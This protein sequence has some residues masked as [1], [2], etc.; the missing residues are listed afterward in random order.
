MKNKYKICIVIPY[1]G[2]WPEW[3]NYFLL[4][5]KYNSSIDWQFFTDC[6]TPEIHAENLTFHPMTLTEF[7]ELAN[8]QLEIQLSVRH[9]YK[10]CDLKPAY[11][12]IFQKY[13]ENY[14]FWGYGDLDLVYGKINDFISD[15]ILDDYDI[16]SNHTDFIAGHFCILRNT[17]QIIHL[18]RKGAYYKKAFLQSKYTGFDEQI[19]N[20]KIST[21]P[22]NLN[23]S[24]KI[25]TIYHLSLNS[26]VNSPVKDVLRPFWKIVRKKGKAELKDF[27]TIVSESQQNEE[28]KVIY[29]TTFQS[30]LMFL[31]RKN[32]NWSLKWDHGKLINEKTGKEILYFHFILSKNS[33]KFR[34]DP[35]PEN[36]QSF[37]IQ[38]S[39]IKI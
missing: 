22:E 24:K 34:I 37:Y 28:I 21:D 25:N 6:G 19:L 27:T 39:E 33:G 3:I 16:I 12:L 2:K 32:R 9:P 11:G 30:D 35:F 29:K 14:D 20:I 31:K 38:P 26:I 4:S 17:P 36:V 15:Q 13:L 23:L 18:F 8:S 1:F 7:N 10:L 5:C